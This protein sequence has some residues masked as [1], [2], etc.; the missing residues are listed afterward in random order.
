[1]VGEREGRGEV[2]GEGERSKGGD[3]RRP[4]DLRERGDGRSTD[5]R[6]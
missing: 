4:T 5:L 2:T 1:M 6:E 3:G